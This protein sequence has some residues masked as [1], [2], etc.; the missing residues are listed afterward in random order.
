VYDIMA[1][2]ALTKAGDL[3]DGS[4]RQPEQDPPAARLRRLIGTSE[5]A[6]RA[7]IPEYAPRWAWW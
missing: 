1:S 6:T 7:A 3:D 2:H 5:A 4:D